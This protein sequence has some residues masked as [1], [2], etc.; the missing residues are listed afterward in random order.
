MAASAA[1]STISSASRS[2]ATTTSSAMAIVTKVT[3][4]TTIPGRARIV[5]AAMTRGTI[6]KGTAI[7]KR[8]SPIT[9]AA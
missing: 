3:A 9:A 4:A 2:G 5:S 6:A 7:S 1:S 8:A